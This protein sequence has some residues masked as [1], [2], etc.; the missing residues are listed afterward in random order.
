MSAQVLFDALLR[1][2]G[3]A[4]A[5]GALF[6]VL[7]AVGRWL[8]RQHEQDAE[9]QAIQRELTVVCRG[10]FACLDGLKQM[11][12]NGTVTAARSELET[13]LNESAHH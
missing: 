10:M 5:A 12:C 4:T 3:L 8:R 2:G 7:A 1:A 13:H 9:I 11:G 6:G